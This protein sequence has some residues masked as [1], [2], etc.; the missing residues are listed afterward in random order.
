MQVRVRL[1]TGTYT[2][3]IISTFQRLYK[4]KT[5]IQAPMATTDKNTQLQA[6]STTTDRNTQQV[7]AVLPLATVIEEHTGSGN[8][9]MQLQTGTQRV[10]LSV[11]HLQAETQNVSL[12]FQVTTDRNTKCSAPLETEILLLYLSITIDT[13][14]GCVLC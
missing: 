6:D 14:T 10:F 4:Q 11:V 1:N 2:R 12:F 13:N 3:N 9:E 5:Q 8:C 7:L